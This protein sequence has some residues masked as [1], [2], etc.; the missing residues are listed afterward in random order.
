[1]WRRRGWLSGGGWFGGFGAFVVF[2]DGFDQRRVF[3]IKSGVEALVCGVVPTTR[4][5]RILLLHVK[6]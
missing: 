1:M 4:F 3:R 2:A 6:P 5:S